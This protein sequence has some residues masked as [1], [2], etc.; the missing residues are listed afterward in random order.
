M[1]R[2]IK[3]LI[4]SALS[5][6]SVLALSA[7]MTAFADI[8]PNPLISRNAPAYDNAGASHSAK[9]GND[10]HYFSFWTVSAPN[11]LAYDLSAVPEEQ[12]KSV[13]AV[14]YNTSS[15]DGIGQY[16]SR[17]MEP[18]SYTIEVNKADGGEYPADGWEIAVTVDDNTLSS[19]QHAV[20]MEG[21]NWIRLNVKNSDG[22]TGSNVSVNFDVHDISGGVSDSWLLLGDSITAGGMH[23]CYGTGFA[24]Y[25]NQLDSRYFPIQEN[26]GIGG[27]RSD[28]GKENIDRW[29]ESYGGKYVSIAYGTND[30]WGN[31]GSGAE[32]YYDN[33]KYMIDAVLASG[34]I[35]VLPKIP[36]STNAD[37]A[38]HLGDF[39]SMIDRLY[40]EYG[41]KLVQGPDFEAYFRENPEG[42]S[43]DGVH[44]SSEGYDGMRRLWAETMYERVYKSE[45]ASPPA[46]EIVYGDAN[47]DGT[48]NLSDAILIMQALGNPDMY[49]IS[50][51]DATHITE[52]GA[53]NGDVANVGDGL[54]NSDA[55]VIQEYLLKL[56]DKLPKN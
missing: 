7:S 33:T 10:E 16:Q 22:G 42:L 27:I 49:G 29:L 54:T 46:D 43:S 13:M 48:V 14:W 55:L 31:D 19:R 40:E 37:V 20:D 34:K 12:R 44:P 17:N 25:V 11:Y 52:K 6:I 4:S 18:F 35:P 36:Y 24:T 5:L 28:D 2:K 9:Q 30:A 47:L 26:G 15:Y 39:N 32:T 8:E 51:N 23:N 21:Y 41:E 38:G 53:I 3:K 50:G 1:K 56:V 45:T